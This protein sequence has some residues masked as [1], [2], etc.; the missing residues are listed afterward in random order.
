MQNFDHY[1]IDFVL[2]AEDILISQI[3]ERLGVTKSM[4]NYQDFEDAAYYLL[5]ALGDSMDANDGEVT[6]DWFVP[7]FRRL[8]PEESMFMS[9]W[10]YEAGLIQGKVGGSVK[11]VAIVL[12]P[13]VDT[14]ESVMKDNLDDAAALA[15]EARGPIW[16]ERADND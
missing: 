16:T 4:K 6:D 13:L 3:A 9:Q 10:A 15:Y 12:T 11:A 8:S 7:F 5:T 2:N 1:Y 14:V